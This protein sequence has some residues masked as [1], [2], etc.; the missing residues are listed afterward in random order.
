MGRTSSRDG[1]VKKRPH[2]NGVAASKSGDCGNSLAAL[3]RKQ[4][5]SSLV[6]TKRLPPPQ[7]TISLARRL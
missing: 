2:L 7:T 5:V 1:G 4:R 6:A 3:H